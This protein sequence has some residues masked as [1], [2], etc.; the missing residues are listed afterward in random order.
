[1]ELISRKEKMEI[2]RDITLED[3]IFFSKC[4]DGS[5]ECASLMLRIILE[6][7][8]LERVRTR[9]QKWI[10]NIRNHSVKLDILA[11]DPEGNMYD[12]EI[13]KADNG[14]TRRRARYYSAAM[15]TEN[16]D[17]GRGYE[18][19]PESYVIFITSGDAIGAGKAIYEIDRYIG[20]IMK[21]F[22]DGTHIIYVSTSLADEDTDLGRLIHDLRCPDPDKMFYNELRERARYFK[23]QTEGITDMGSAFEDVMQKIVQEAMEKTR[24]KSLEEGRLEGEANGLRKGRTEGLREGRQEVARSMVAD[25]SIPLSKIAE[26]SGL[27]LGEVENIRKSMHA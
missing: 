26:F 2:I 21:P 22:D 3:D 20:G 12:I 19:L 18:D 17:K 11:F 5:N 16:F 23:K 7:D 6:R 15:D 25:G 8:D 9:T 13:Q 10:Q 4:L 24:E 1:M 27:T 14:A